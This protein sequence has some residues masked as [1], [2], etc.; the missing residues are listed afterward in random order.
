[1]QFA[2]LGKRMI[3]NH[4]RAQSLLRGD[5]D[6]DVFPRRRMVRQDHIDLI[7]DQR[8]NEFLRCADADIEADVGML[9]LEF[10]NRRR[11]QFARDQFDRGNAD[12][13]AHQPA[14]LFDLQLDGFEL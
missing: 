12:L 4:Q 13:S 1:M 3:V 6:G 8:G 2:A 11:Q 9:D 14:Q 5:C 10:G 7:G